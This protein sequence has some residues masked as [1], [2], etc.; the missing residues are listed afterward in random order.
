MKN[1]IKCCSAII[2]I[3]F[4]SCDGWHRNCAKLSQRMV[5]EHDIVIGPDRILFFSKFWFLFTHQRKATL[6]HAHWMILYQSCL[7]ICM[8]NSNRTP[9]RLAVT[10]PF[11]NGQLDFGDTNLKIVFDLWFAIDWPFTSIKP[12]ALDILKLSTCRLSK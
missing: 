5:V 9:N 6:S 11:Q 3:T 2:I 10:W 8:G 4:F 7:L 1:S 12:Y